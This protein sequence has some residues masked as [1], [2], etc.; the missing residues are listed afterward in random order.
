VAEHILGARVAVFATDWR[1]P[2]WRKAPRPFAI[3]VVVD[4]T[5]IV[6]TAE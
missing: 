2:L 3:T 4:G 5:D 6:V 1:A